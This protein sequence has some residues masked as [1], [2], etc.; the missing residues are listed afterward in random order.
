MKPEGIL[1]GEMRSAYIF[2]PGIFLSIPDRENEARLIRP[3]N[4]RNL[5]PAFSGIFSSSAG[6][7]FPGKTIRIFTSR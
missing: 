1:S 5:F 6:F 2:P 7:I 4:W 3:E